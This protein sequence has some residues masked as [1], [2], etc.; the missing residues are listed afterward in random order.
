MKFLFLFLFLMV[1]LTSNADEAQIVIKQKKGGNTILELSTNPVITLTNESLVVTND[2]TVI[3]I[4]LD[5]IDSYVVTNGTAG[6]RQPEKVAHYV[7]GHVLFSN[8]PIGSVVKVFT[9]DGLL[10]SRHFVDDTGNA[11][12]SL[13]ALPK[14][15]YIISSLYNK[16]KVINK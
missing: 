1:S 13:D 10:I 5:N 4:P 7:N 16:I 8:L 12:I 6:I 14:K 9:I 3:A 15:S 2:F 11:D